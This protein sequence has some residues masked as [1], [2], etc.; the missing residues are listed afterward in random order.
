MTLSGAFVFRGPRALVWD[1]LHD[2]DVLMTAMPGARRLIRTS[3]DRYEGVMR[4]GLGPV[5]AAEFTLTVT[6]GDAVAPERF[7]MTIDSQGAVGFTRGTAR[8]EL[9]DADGSA[10]TMT[11]T[12]DLQVGGRIASVGQRVVESAARTMTAKGLEALQR[13]LDARLAQTG[14]GTRS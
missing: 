8:V 3:D 2:P 13:A 12:A 5:T 9:K 6:I 7:T 1:L 11:Y 10:T 4:V 14:G